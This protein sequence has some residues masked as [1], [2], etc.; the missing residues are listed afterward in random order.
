MT[1]ITVI[2]FFHTFLMGSHNVGD[3][4]N[5]MEVGIVH[6]TLEITLFCAIL[7]AH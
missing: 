3:L 6:M 1:L 5:R 2:W 4:G 7:E